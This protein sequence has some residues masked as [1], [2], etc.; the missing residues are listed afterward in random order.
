MS[1]M[2]EQTLEEVDA[3]VFSGDYLVQPENRVKFQEYL[4]RWKRE[5]DSMAETFPT[6]DIEDE[7]D[8]T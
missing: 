1:I 5:L 4:D 3:I 8:D 2:D 6:G 7:E